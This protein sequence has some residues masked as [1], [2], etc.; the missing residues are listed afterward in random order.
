MITFQN[1]KDEDR[2][3][4]EKVYRSTREKELLFAYLPEEQKGRFIAMQLT[5]QLADYNLNFKGASYQMIIYKGTPAGR[6]YLW[7]SKDEIR[8]L[9]I[10]LLPEFQNRGI[11]STILN[12]IIKTAT[13]KN[14][15]I[16]LHVAI[17]N[18]AKNLYTRLG[19]KKIR[20]SFTH[21][22]MELK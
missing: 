11:G 22:Y 13:L 5:S 1:I 3:F 15:I 19:F 9:D 4:I 16:S 7:E 10:S 17:G 21:E 8:V 2:L 18:P 14:K 12:D 20:S 6:L